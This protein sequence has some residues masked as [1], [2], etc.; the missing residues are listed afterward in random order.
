MIQKNNKA[1]DIFESVFF[2]LF[3]C[4]ITLRL[5][6]MENPSIES[7]SIQGIFYDNFLSISISSLLIICA[8]I[9]F[10]V[11]LSVG[12]YRM[13][14]FEYGVLIFIIGCVISVIAASNRRAA[15]TDS[16]TIL[17][18]MLTAVVLSNLLG[19]IERKK[20]LL[21]AIIAMGIA[22]AYQCTDQFFSSN[23]FMIEQYESDPAEQLRALGIEPGSFQQMLYEHRLYSKDV[24]GFF[25]TGNSAGSL[26]VLAIFCTFAA[27]DF[28]VRFSE[29]KNAIKKLWL[30][31]ILLF[32]LFA[33]LLEAHS[34]GAIASLIGAAFLLLIAIKFGKILKRRLILT[35]IAVI[36]LIVIC[37]I[38]V[39]GY[40][41]THN[42]L[43][44]GNS[45]LV[46][47]QYWSA[48]VKIIADHLMTGIGGGNF[49]EYYTRYKIPQALESVKDPHCFIL[50]ILSQYGI[51]GL[52]GFGIAAFYPIIKACIQN[53][54]AAKSANNIT[55][56]AKAY[57]ISAVLVL[58]V[59]RPLATRVDLAGN[60]INVI[61]YVL[62]IMYAVP[63]FCFGA[64]LWLC[65]RTEKTLKT[66]QIFQPA[67]LCGI[68]A[69]LIHNLIDFAI[70][71][72]GIMT[73]LWASI[74]IVYSDFRIENLPANA[75]KP[76]K[77]SKLI[78]T[79][80][81]AALTAAIIW[82]CIIPAAK[83]AFKTEKAKQFSSRGEFQKATMLLNLASADDVL[84]PTPA[85]LAGKTLLYK[86]EMNPNNPPEVLSQAESSLQTAIKRDRADF[87]NYENLAKVYETF[88]KINNNK[89]RF[90]L[91][92]AFPAIQQALDRY[93]S[94]AQMHVEFAKIAR[95]LGKIDL[96][97]EH[98]KKAIEIEDAFT[99]Q[100]KIMYPG[101]ATFSRMDKTKYQ[102]AKD[103]LEELTQLGEN[104]KQ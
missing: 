45:M 12:K 41:V 68:F 84:N 1:F 37:L 62:G 21:Y 36:V 49:G 38:S 20:I 27:F 81:A 48:T 46:R 98:Y 95:Q 77:T 72:P 90:W 60:S 17:S 3:A 58:L 32:I 15:I 9:W 100:L 76:K 18:A 4:V 86:F 47:W 7:F 64:A 94:S 56:A 24:K 19:T 78:L 14:G 29:K 39:I 52:A 83:T 70:F 73:V 10:A 74:A 88:A 92:E 87:K 104:P 8:I 67:L 55:A 65:A 61:L 97:I 13:S 34:K 80:S 85:A 35:I 31:I 54:T 102:E 11:R 57:G 16:I 25:T 40:G 101:K 53:S 51:I 23:Q 71:E 30:P 42:T 43:P 28:R 79:V 99:E 6:F 59:V 82:F 66:G 50:S 69:V 75:S 63:A 44:G 89:E 2:V 91:E 22:N 103:K 96:A 33:G 26:F 93:P 5:S